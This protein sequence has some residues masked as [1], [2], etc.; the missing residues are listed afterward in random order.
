[1]RVAV[2]V[3]LY[4][5]IAV[6]VAV[7]V[8]SSIPPCTGSVPDGR[9]SQACIDAWLAQRSVIDWLLSTP[10]PEIAGFVAASAGTIWWSRRRR[11]SDRARRRQPRSR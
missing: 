2:L 6:V 10:Y 3:L 7:F 8:G 9:M 5:L 1:M 11:V 4:A